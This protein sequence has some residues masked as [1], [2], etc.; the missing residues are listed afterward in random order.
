MEWQ[1][2]VKELYDNVVLK[3]PE[4]VRP[5]IKPE[6]FQKAEEKCEQRLGKYVAEVDLIVAL[7]EITPTA[8]QPTM[9]EDLKSLEV[10]YNRYLAK[11]K[12][13][14]KCTNDLEQMVKDFAKL[15][16]IADVNFNENA[17]RNVFNVYK[18]FFSGAPIS[19]R[20]TTKPVEYRDVALRYVEFFM[21]HHPDPYTKAIN[22]GLIEKDNHPIHE[23]VKEVM[24]TFQMMGYGVD[25]DA[26]TGLSKIW[27][28][29]VPG[30]IEPLFSMKW[31]PESMKK[32]RDYFI[33]HDLTA[34]SLFAF[35]FLHKTMNIYFMLQQ[36]PKAA[37]DNC[38]ALA[39]ELGFKIPSKEAMEGCMKAVHLNYTFSWDSEKIERFCYG[40]ACDDPEEVPVHFHP[41]MKKFVDETPL[42]SDSR[43]FIW[44][45][46][47][48]N[49][50]LYYKIENDYNGAM[51]DFLSLGCKAGLET[52]K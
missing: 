26:S 13:D 34:F 30:T 48:T 5:V 45:V 27:P 37:Y 39:E 19:I 3:M 51:I 32:Y 25:V 42:Q 10:D 22:E 14:F 44:G 11:V 43:K 8:F 52:Y 38:V 12:S 17:T 16:E 2:E 40:M 21:P 15:C 9:I 31:A 49:N 20:T 7:F 18:E 41:L 50:G 4:M 47:F 28:F 33:K 23:M 46:T 24:D 36:P 35:D 1:P 6:L 29:I